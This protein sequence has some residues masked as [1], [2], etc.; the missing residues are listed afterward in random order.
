[1]KL[2]KKIKLAVQKYLF[3]RKTPLNGK[4]LQLLKQSLD[5]QNPLYWSDL[6]QFIEKLN[7]PFEVITN[8]N[9]TNKNITLKLTELNTSYKYC[10]G[11]DISEFSDVKIESINILNKTIFK[12]GAYQ[13]DF[14]HI[15]ITHKKL[16]TI[17]NSPISNKSKQA[18]EPNEAKT[19][20]KLADLALNQKAG[21][22][23]IDESEGCIPESQQIAYRVNAAF[24]YPS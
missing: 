17:N 3:L 23:K 20:E 19:W 11:T 8:K 7:F 13:S 18:I 10:R 24:K 21:I 22:F 12:C 6:Q 14:Y 16:P 5:A 4:H 1:M 2:F 9:S 15:S